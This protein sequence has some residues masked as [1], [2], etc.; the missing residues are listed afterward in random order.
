MIHATLVIPS[1][2]ME[3]QMQQLPYHLRHKLLRNPNLLQSPKWKYYW[4]PI[5]SQCRRWSYQEK[6][7]FRREYN[8]MEFSTYFL[9]ITKALKLKA[10]VHPCSYATFGLI[11]SNLEPVKKKWTVLLAPAAKILLVSVLQK[12]SHLSFYV[13]VVKSKSVNFPPRTHFFIS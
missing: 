9:S 8:E 3:K 4:N 1:D 10:E 2:G 7:L 5:L 13:F 6:S 11:D 12:G